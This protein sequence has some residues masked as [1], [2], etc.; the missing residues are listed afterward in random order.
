MVSDKLSSAGSDQQSSNIFVSNLNVLTKC[1]L[2]WFSS[3]CECEKMFFKE[4]I[5]LDY[6]V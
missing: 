6:N 2:H 3:A 4:I 1:I 5:P